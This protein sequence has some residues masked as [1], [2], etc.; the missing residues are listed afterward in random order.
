MQ[1][2]ELG[3]NTII[4]GLQ[5]SLFKKTFGPSLRFR[6]LNVYHDFTGCLLLRLAFIS[7]AF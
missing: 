1:N 6:E 5:R 3:F 7:V 2:G 4:I